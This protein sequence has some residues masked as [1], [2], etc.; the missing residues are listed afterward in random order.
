MDI[1]LIIA[2]IVCVL[3]GVVGSVMPAIPG[4]PL[5]FIGLILLELTSK[6]HFSI[7]ILIFCGLLVAVTLVTD[8][9]LPILGVKKWN[10]TKWGNIGCMVGVVLGIFILPPWGLLIFPFLGAVLGEKLISKKETRAAVKAGFGA[11]IGFV[12]STVLKL[13]VCGFFIFLFFREVALNY[14]YII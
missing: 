2:G 8:Y 14:E 1:F 12:L 3:G 13:S 5:S 11:F 7:W 10:G 9:L 4:P 6:V